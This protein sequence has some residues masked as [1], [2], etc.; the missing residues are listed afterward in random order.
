MYHFV[1]SS[2]ILK[3]LLT[4]FEGNLP[5]CILLNEV[6][7]KTTILQLTHNTFNN[8]SRL[9]ENLYNVVNIFNNLEES[10]ELWEVLTPGFKKTIIVIILLK[11]LLQEPDAKLLSEKSIQY[12]YKIDPLNTLNIDNFVI[13]NYQKNCFSNN[14]NLEYKLYNFILTLGLKIFGIPFH[15]IKSEITSCHTVYLNICL[16][17][18]QYLLSYHKIP[19]E[20]ALNVYLKND[21]EAVEMFNFAASSYSARIINQV[22]LPLLSTSK[23]SI[24]NEYPQVIRV[25]GFYNHQSLKI[26]KTNTLI[27]ESYSDVYKAIFVKQIIQS[28]IKQIKFQNELKKSK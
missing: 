8:D 25:I 15:R 21:E 18:E 19:V 7:Y 16:E 20:L 24:L 1:D 14:K 12:L 3:V 2:K 22:I 23:N 9:F 27:I 10:N 26:K 28:H 4:L 5:F 17:L 6:M 11:N 13:H